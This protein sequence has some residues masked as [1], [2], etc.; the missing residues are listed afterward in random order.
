M[1]DGGPAGADERVVLYVEDVESSALL[2]DRALRRLPNVRVVM[3]KNGHE[4]R[5]FIAS[6]SCAL[7]LSDLNLPDVSG[8]EW[9]AELV[10]S[11]RD[12]RIPVVVVSAD[13]TSAS[14]EAVLAA[15][16]TGYL[17]KPVD[18]RELIAVVGELTSAPP[19]T[20]GA[21]PER[22]GPPRALVE[23][24]L[25]EAAADL[26][27]LRQAVVAGELSSVESLAHRLKGSSAVFGAA[28]LATVLDRLEAMARDQVID[29][30]F[31]L[32]DE[33]DAALVRF[34]A[35]LS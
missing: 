23:R 26:A 27:R 12:A 1:T 2:V 6:T 14:K 3:A 17:T 9:V 25:A 28:D 29:G 11:V 30:A 10:A 31:G 16:A 21:G 34:R 13:A 33:A 4:A 35:E 32:V 8:A 18:L 22:E 20:P 15:G 24:Y 19:P 5:E 7:V